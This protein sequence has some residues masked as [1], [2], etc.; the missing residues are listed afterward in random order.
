MAGVH[1][2]FALRQGLAQK[3]STECYKPIVISDY[4]FPT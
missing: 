1:L 4:G 2:L 3:V